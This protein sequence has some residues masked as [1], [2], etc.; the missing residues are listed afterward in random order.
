MDAAIREAQRTYL[1]D[2]AQENKSER[3]MNWV[4]LSCDAQNPPLKSLQA[5]EAAARLGSFQ[6]LYNTAREVT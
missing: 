4:H 6:F 3:L 5:F 2:T 1:T